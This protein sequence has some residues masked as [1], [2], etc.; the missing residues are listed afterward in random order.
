M[1]ELGKDKDHDIYCQSWVNVMRNGE[2]IARHNHWGF[3]YT[4]LS[5]HICVAANGTNTN[6][7]NPISGEKWSSPNRFG[8]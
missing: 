8:K 1:D 2:K 6:Y 7:Y 4:Y 3:D 5:A